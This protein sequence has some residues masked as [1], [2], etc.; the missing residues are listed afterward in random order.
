[1]ASRRSA[2]FAFAAGILAAVLPGAAR[3]QGNLTVYC[4]VQEEWC[5]PMMAA[6][7]RAT[8][9]RVAMTRKSSGETLTQIRA[10]ASNPRGDVWWGG[11]GD[12]HM[13]AGQ[14]NLTE[15]YR[16][17]R[18]PELQPW[19]VRQAEQ[20]NFRTV[21]IYAGALGYSYNTRELERRRITAP[22]CWS[23]LAKPEFRGEVQVA[24]PNTS[25]TAYTMLATLVQVMGEEPAFTYLRALH[26]N[27]NQYTRS[28]AAPARAA[29]TGE[30]LVGI[31]FLHDA[32]TQKIAGAPVNIVAPCEG[33]GYE[34]GSMSIIRGARNMEN[35]RRFYDWAL[36]PEAQAIAGTA[37]SF[38]LPSN[39]ASP[40][41]PQAPRFEDVRLIDYDFAR[42]GS[43]EERTRLLT[44]WE[45]EVR[46][47]AR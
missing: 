17:P 29:A 47:G 35:A 44:R 28:G 41:P 11:T 1:M 36:S 30:T 22:R 20:A 12:P 2:V 4:S 31:T 14:E 34:I 40:I 37:N 43:A 39:R 18:L 24:D 7:E 42:W 26:R 10:E 16:S 23:D 21:G 6:F 46:A 33:T 9:V 19:A 13:Q 15:E 45:R 3:A 27:V 5:R 25:G 32:V 8:G 38:Q